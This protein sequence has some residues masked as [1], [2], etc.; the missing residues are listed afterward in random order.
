MKRWLFRDI[1]NF[2][3]PSRRHEISRHAPLLRGEKP[4]KNRNNLNRL[5]RFE[6]CRQL[7]S[8][9]KSG[10]HL[11]RIDAAAIWYGARTLRIPARQRSQQ[12]PP[13]R[14]S[15]GIADAA[16]Q[17]IWVNDR[18]MRLRQRRVTLRTSRAARR[19]A[20]KAVSAVTPSRGTGGSTHGPRTRDRGGRKDSKGSS[21]P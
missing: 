4:R 5:S 19:S 10:I 15:L 12:D 20:R 18:A 11:A 14:A 2:P 7:L 16:Q 9:Q 13:P 1:G 17:I 21:D 8:H 3:A 6:P